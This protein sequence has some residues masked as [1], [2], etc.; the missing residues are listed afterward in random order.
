MYF[1]PS[2][3]NLSTCSIR[4]TEFFFLFEWCVSLLSYASSVPSCIG[5]YINTSSFSEWYFKKERWKYLIRNVK[6]FL[7]FLTSQIRREK[8]IFLHTYL[9]FLEYFVPQ[10]VWFPTFYELTVFFHLKE[11]IRC[12]FYWQLFL[13]FLQKKKN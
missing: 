10:T 5:K 2:F 8:N 12:Q 1:F 13:Y 11:L 9:C 7:Q 4:N 6:Q 3:S